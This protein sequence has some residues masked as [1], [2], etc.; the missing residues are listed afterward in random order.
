MCV[1][2]AEECLPSTL[3]THLH[4]KALHVWVG[5]VE[6]KV[7]G[8]WGWGGMCVCVLLSAGMT[9]SKHGVF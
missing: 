4:P 3:V 6:W 2:C 1:V 9:F 7:G 8:T 5:V